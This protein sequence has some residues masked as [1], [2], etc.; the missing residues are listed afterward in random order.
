VLLAT[1]IWQRVVHDCTMNSSGHARRGRRGRKDVRGDVC[2]DGRLDALSPPIRWKMKRRS[3]NR[4]CHTD[5]LAKKGREGDAPRETLVCLHAFPTRLLCSNTE[6]DRGHDPDVLSTQRRSVST[7]RRTRAMHQRCRSQ[8]RA[9]AAMTAPTP[10]REDGTDGISRGPDTV[11]SGQ[12]VRRSACFTK[13]PLSLTRASELGEVHTTSSEA[14]IDRHHEGSGC[15]RI[16]PGPRGHRA[17]AHRLAHRQRLQSA[18][19][20]AD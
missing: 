5:L 4:R 15:G 14:L 8:R 9:G 20:G 11:K 13:R 16:A 3:M 19:R 1:A 2:V 6:R 17:T 18:V 7:E 12:T 10:K